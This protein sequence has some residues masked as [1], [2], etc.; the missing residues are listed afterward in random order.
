MRSPDSWEVLDLDISEALSDTTVQN[1]AFHSI[2]SIIPRSDLSL[3]HST[4]NSEYNISQDAVN[5]I[6]T[7]MQR[8]FADCVLRGINCTKDADG[9]GDINGYLL[10]TSIEQYHPGIAKVLWEAADF[11]T[12]FVNIAASMSNAIRNGADASEGALIPG[13]LGVPT[14]VYIV[15]WWWITLHCLVE[16]VT[17]LFL[18]LTALVTSRASRGGNVRIPVW[19]TSSLASVSRARNATEVL[20]SLDTVKSMEEKAKQFSVVLLDGNKEDDQGVPL[21][22]RGEHVVSVA[23]RRWYRRRYRRHRGPVT[24]ANAT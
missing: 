9:W 17:V 23:F 24:R 19:K 15:N 13:R 20:E 11:N 8:T 4:S 5:G 6:S 2:D 18:A 16:L 3:R 7:F 22:E 10:R 21:V 1:L 14:T 12:T